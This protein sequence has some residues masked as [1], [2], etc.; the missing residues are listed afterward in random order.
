MYHTILVPLDGTK[1][2]E[3]ILPQVE[4]L[5]RLHAARVLFLRVLQPAP[6]LARP[7]GAGP[8]LRAEPQAQE[9]DTATIYLAGKRGE[10]RELGLP[11]ATCLETGPVVETILRVAAQSGADLI[12]MASHGRTALEQLGSRSVAAGLLHGSQCPLLLVR[13]CN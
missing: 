7:A 5:A 10:F 11:A 1:Q 2:A 13:S 9:W 12:A 4:M 8:A 6:V 3:A